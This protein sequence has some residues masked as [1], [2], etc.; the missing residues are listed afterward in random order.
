MAFRAAKDEIA[1]ASI[2]ERLED[3]DDASGQRN[4]MPAT[5]LHALGWHGP[6]GLPQVDLAPDGTSRSPERA[7]VRIVNSNAFADVP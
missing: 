3:L 2:V 4:D 6:D 5:S 1:L 7:A